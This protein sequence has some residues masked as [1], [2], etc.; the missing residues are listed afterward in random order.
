MKP[1]VGWV[2][3]LVGELG[4]R[5]TFGGPWGIRWMS[6]KEMTTHS[7]VLAWRIPGTEEPGGVY[8]V[9][10]SRTWL[11]W[12]S[13]SSRGIWC[14]V[15]ISEAGCYHP[16]SGQRETREEKKSGVSPPLQVWRSWATSKSLLVN[17][18]TFVCVWRDDVQERA[19][20]WAQYCWWANKGRLK[21]DQSI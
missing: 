3:A 6:E 15:K 19:I 5:K 12:L 4:T 10:Q 7:S 18:R 1:V 16:V 20:S 8:G 17:R 21:I 9:A 11:K 13:S 14:G 2:C